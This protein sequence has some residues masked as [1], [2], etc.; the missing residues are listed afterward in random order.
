MWKHM[1]RIVGEVRPRYVFVENSPLLV[2]RGLAVVIG[3]LTALGYDAEWFCLSASDLGAPHQRDRIWLVGHT[4]SDGWAQGW[5]ADGQHERNQPRPADQHT[6]QMA[7]ADSLR[8][9]QQER[10][11][12][13]QRGRAGNSSASM[14]DT[15]LLLGNEGRPDHAEERTR[16]RHADRGGIGKDMAHAGH[17]NGKR[18]VSGGADQ[19][20]RTGPQQRQAGPCGYGIGWWPAE[21]DVGRV[22]NGVAAR[23]DRLK[24]IGNGQVSRVA[25]TAF[26]FLSR[27]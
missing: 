19:K 6:G 15:N 9:P 23:V 18:I 13:E 17:L 11:Q 2:G 4:I 20:G 24:A 10:C 25:A 8:Q 1:A 5:N 27:G 12:Q 26:N 22:A 14:A 21:P 7:D 16:G 3:D